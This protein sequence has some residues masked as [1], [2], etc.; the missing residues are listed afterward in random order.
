MLVSNPWL[1][2]AALLA[3]GAITG[4]AYIKGR[5]D[6]ADKVVAKQAREDEIRLET[7]QIAQLAAAEE[8]AKIQVVNRT[9]YAK[10]TRQVIEKPVYRD[11]VHDAA[12]LSLLNSAL[13]N[14][15]VEPAG[16]S[17]VPRADTA[18]W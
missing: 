18:R 17:G 14:T 1:I 8:I 7:L 9:I 4:G 10:A 6:G 2:L 12:T 15:P 16:D 11:C 3:L 13:T 5:Q